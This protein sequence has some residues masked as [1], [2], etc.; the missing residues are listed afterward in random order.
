MDPPFPEGPQLS[1][2]Q[3]LKVV[4]ELSVKSGDTL[5]LKQPG[6]SLRIMVFFGNKEVGTGPWKTHCFPFGVETKV[7]AWAL[8]GWR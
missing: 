6:E 3:C 7:G 8:P 1:P 2:L 5:L 4:V